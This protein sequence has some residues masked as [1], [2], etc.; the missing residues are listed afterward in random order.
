MCKAN[1]ITSKHKQLYVRFD[2]SIII[3][4]DFN[5]FLLLI[6]LPNHKKG[7]KNIVGIDKISAAYLLAKSNGYI[8]HSQKL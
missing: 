8:K 3:Q 2:R 5:S 7:N 4:G 1:N 6:Y